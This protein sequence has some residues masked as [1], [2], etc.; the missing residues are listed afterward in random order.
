MKLLKEKQRK[1]SAGKTHMK[2]EVYEFVK[3]TI[4]E[5]H[6]IKKP[7]VAPKLQETNTSEEAEESFPKMMKFF[8]KINNIIPFR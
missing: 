1:T 8:S 6:T 4:K 7:K 2:S 3:M 5:A